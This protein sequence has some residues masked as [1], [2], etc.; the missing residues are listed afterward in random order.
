M[1]ILLFGRGVITTLYGWAFEKAG[2]NVTFYVRPGRSA[3]YGSH[4]HLDILDGRRGTERKHVDEDWAIRMVDEL[5][6]ILGDGRE[7]EVAL[8]L[9]E[10]DHAPFFQFFNHECGHWYRFASA[11]RTLADVSDGVYAAQRGI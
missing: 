7:E 5:R 2:H 1:N 11:L 4:V 8:G 10:S 6:S 9:I 3:E